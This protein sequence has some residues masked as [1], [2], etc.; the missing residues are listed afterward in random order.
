MIHI[1]VGFLKIQHNGV[2]KSDA[3]S[4]KYQKMIREGFLQP[5]SNK[6]LLFWQAHGNAEVFPAGN[7]VFYKGHY[8][9]GMYILVSGCAAVNYNYYR[10]R[11]QVLIHKPVILGANHLVHFSPYKYSVKTLEMTRFI[12]I[13]RHELIQQ[14]DGKSLFSGL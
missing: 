1:M 10:K 5:V 14:L 4:I 12:F 8:P 9:F 13:P 7:T 3:H 6:E 11:H 2:V